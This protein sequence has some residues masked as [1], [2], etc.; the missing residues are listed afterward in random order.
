MS[1]VEHAITDWTQHPASAL[2]P[3]MTDEEYAD[4]RDDVAA[5]ALQVPIVLLDGM[6]LDGRHR[7]R[8]CLETGAQIR[9]E[10][11]DGE[12][13]P[14]TWV[15]S[16]NLHRRHLTASQRATL[17]VE[18]EAFYAASAEARMK[19]GRSAS[20]S[21]PDD[22]SSLAAAGSDPRANLPQ[23]PKGRA[24][25]QAAK[26]VGVSRR[27][28]QDAKKVKE[29]A[30]DLFEKVKAGDVTVHDAVQ[31]IVQKERAAEEKAEYEAALAEFPELAPDQSPGLPP[32]E[33]VRVANDLRAVPEEELPA[34]RQAAA[35]WHRAYALQQQSGE[36]DAFKKGDDVVSAVAAMQAAVMRLGGADAVVDAIEAALDA[37][38]TADQWRAE[39]ESA[40]QLLADLAAACKPGIRRVK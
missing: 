1:A 34:R 2:L 5:N 20:S 9:S 33:V 35:T 25:D 13:D 11:W 6:V 18:A 10:E 7:L 19:A 26:T 29:S 38:F 4:L 15:L 32:S 22:M 30:P 24:L 23:G 40:Q 17:A 8:A 39:I 14:L 37:V 16:V 27:A 3:S 21:S 31:R 12:G 28:A 36:P